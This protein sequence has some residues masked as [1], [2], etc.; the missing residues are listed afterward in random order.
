MPKIVTPQTRAKD[1]REHARSVRR[2]A[3]SLPSNADAF[4]GMTADE[5]AT[6]AK[7]L[8]AS[9]CWLRRNASALAEGS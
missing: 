8:E 6:A 7:Q 3:A 1:A 2:A 9:G 5:I 4:A